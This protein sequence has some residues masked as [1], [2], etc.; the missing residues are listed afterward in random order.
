MRWTSNLDNKHIKENKKQD[1]WAEYLEP[2][3]AIAIY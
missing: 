1:I 2:Q 3:I